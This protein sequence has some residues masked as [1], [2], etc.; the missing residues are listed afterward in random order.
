MNRLSYRKHLYLIHMNAGNVGEAEETVIR[1]T[2]SKAHTSGVEQALVGQ[3]GGALV[4]VH[5]CYALS[6]KA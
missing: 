2:D 4:T 1:I 6:D 5:D 3:N